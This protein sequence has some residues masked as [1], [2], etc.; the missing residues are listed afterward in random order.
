MSGPI[1]DKTNSALW[2]GIHTKK[3]SMRVKAPG[4]SS[5]PI[6]SESDQ[7]EL[8][9]GRVSISSGPGI[10]PNIVGSSAP[11]AYQNRDCRPHVKGHSARHTLLQGRSPTAVEAGFTKMGTLAPVARKLGTSVSSAYRR[12]NCRNGFSSQAYEAA[13]SPTVIGS[14][15]MPR[16]QNGHRP[17]VCRRP[18]FVISSAN[19]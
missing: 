15:T 3:Y 14:P 9:N 19:K 12:F 8:A 5:S 1:S 11:D 4:A 10:R 6:Q 7:S 18:S 16:S 13:A 2:S 17:M